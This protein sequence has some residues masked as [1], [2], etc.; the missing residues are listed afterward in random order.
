MFTPYPFFVSYSGHFFEQVFH[1]NPRKGFEPSRNL[2]GH[3]REI[4]GHLIHA[5]GVSPGGDDGDLIDMLQGSGQGAYHFGHG[6]NEFVDHGSLVPFLVRLGF[7]VHRFGFCFPFE[8]GDGSFGFAL[9]SDSNGAALGFGNEALLFSGGQRLNVAAF[10]FSL[11]ENGGNQ[12]ALD[13]LDFSVLHQNRLLMLH[14]LNLDLFHHHLL[15]HDVGLDLVGL[16]GLGL[17]PLD[18]FEVLG[19]LD[20][21][22]AL[23]FGLVGEGKG[24][25]K[26][27]FLVSLGCG[28][29]PGLWRM[30]V[31]RSA[32]A[33]ATSAC[34]LMRAMSGRPMLEM[35]SFLAG[36]SSMVKEMTSRPI[37]D[38]SPARGAQPVSHHFGLFDDL[39]DGELANDAA[40]VT[41]HDETDES[42]TVVI[43]LGEELLGCGS[44]RFRVALNFDL[45]DR[46]HSVGDALAGVEI[47][48][49]ATSK[50]M[51][52]RESSRAVSSMG[53]TTVPRPLI[54]RVPRKP[55]TIKAWCGPALRNNRA[56][57]LMSIST[58]SAISATITTIWIGFSCVYC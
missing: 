42:F 6:G 4:A 12:F 1:S 53:K 34:R 45:G 19:L 28:D 58:A 3:F 7:D 13:A 57:M 32:S 17:L 8:E 24:L 16:V 39:F 44:D 21:Q 41:F 25:G 11:F 47:L 27:A 22:V 9:G 55:W 20:L 36:T 56:N 14:L 23:G 49:G 37:L 50:L 5:G 15:L 51:S 46:F 18:S 33:P 52:S 48:S 54:T 2:G 31:S 35:Y 29:K 26:D 43:A 40:E 10:D 30:A 38:I